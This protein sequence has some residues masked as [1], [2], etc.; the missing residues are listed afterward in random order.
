[1]A[2]IQTQLD[3]GAVPNAISNVCPPGT[4]FQVLEVGWLECDKGF[5]IRGGNTSTKS[6]ETGSFVNERCE[7]PMYCILIDHPHEG[8]ILWETGSGKDYPTVWGPA[9]ADIFARVKYE[10]RH[11]LRA[12]VEATGHKLDDIKKIIIG[13]LHLDHAGG[14]DEFLH[15]TDVEVWVH[16]KELTNAFW[17][18]ATGADVGVYLEHYLKLSLYASLSPWLV[19]SMANGI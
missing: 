16:E 13:H 7:M 5:V 10:P 18:V 14:L 1:M 2:G 9:I 17:S 11:E 4:K 3:Q 19:W 6:T 12:A 8:L 15:R